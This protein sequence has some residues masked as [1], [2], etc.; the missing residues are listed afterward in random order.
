MTAWSPIESGGPLHCAT[1]ADSTAVHSVRRPSENAT[2]PVG[3]P[4]GLVT[5]AVYAIHCLARAGLGVAESGGRGRIRDAEQNLAGPC[6]R[7]SGIPG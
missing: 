2:L 1:P 6:Q 5:V 7:R 4:P 3:V